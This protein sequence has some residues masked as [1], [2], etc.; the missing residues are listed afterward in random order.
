MNKHPPWSTRLLLGTAS[1]YVL[2][3]T[4]LLLT[5]CPLAPWGA[6]GEAIETAV[7]STF[8]DLI[9]HAVAYAVLAS[10]LVVA[11]RTRFSLACS[12]LAA[13]LLA[14]LHGVLCEA[15]QTFVPARSFAWSDLAANVIGAFGGVASGGLA[16]LVPQAFVATSSAAATAHVR[17][18]ES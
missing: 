8:G 14:S 5:P 15:S 11:I 13:W 1:A 3:L 9:E 18:A 6:A 2:L 16:L 10:L 7:D 12:L 17:R 4:Y